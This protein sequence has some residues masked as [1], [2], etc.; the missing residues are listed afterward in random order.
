VVLEIRKK[1]R[2]FIHEFENEPEQFDK[3]FGLGE[4][5]G[6]VQNHGS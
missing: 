4:F 3:T 5:L 1:E 2:Y 6:M